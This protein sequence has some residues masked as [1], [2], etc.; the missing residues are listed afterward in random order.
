MPDDIVGSLI[1]AMDRAGSGITAGAAEYT[2]QHRYPDA[3]LL[4]KR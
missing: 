2:F 1:D 4:E 3:A